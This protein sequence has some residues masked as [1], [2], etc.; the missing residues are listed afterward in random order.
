MTAEYATGLKRITERVQK[1]N[2][3]NQDIISAFAEISNDYR[4]KDGSW[5]WVSPT[6]SKSTT[7]FF[8]TL[9]AKLHPP[10]GAQEQ[11]FSDYLKKQ[12]SA[13]VEHK[14]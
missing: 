3:R 7:E 4:N 8:R 11:T 6:Y 13:L 14:M 9:N 5:P 10:Q 12:V 1:G 2:I